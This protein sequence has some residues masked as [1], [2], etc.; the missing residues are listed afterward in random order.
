MEKI[1]EMVKITSDLIRIRSTHDRQDQIAKCV[2][3]VADFF[4]ETELKVE[5][6]ESDGVA[7]LVVTKNTNS[8]TVFLCGHVDVVDGQEKQFL[9][10]I[11]EDKIFGRGAMDMKSG[12]AIM[13]I[14]M[15]ELSTTE[16]NFGLMIV[17]DE[18]IGGANGS[19][20][21][22][23]KGYRCK[24]VVIADGGEKIN[25]II[26]KEK[27][28]LR[29]K[30]TA[31]GKSTHSSRPW[32]GINANEILIEAIQKIKTLFI[33][34][35]E[36]PE[37]HWVKT[38]SVGKI[39]GGIAYNQVPASAQAECNIRYTENETR[40]QIISSIKAVLP[41]NVEIEYIGICDGF[42]LEKEDSMVQEYQKAIESVGKTPEFLKT[43]GGSDAGYFAK[44]GI[45]VLMSQPEGANLHA[46]GE[47]V[48]I[49]SMVDYYKMLRSFLNSVALK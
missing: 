28:S 25:R 22:L 23:E 39:N 18:E 31:S 15:K 49:S 2:D 30:L 38:L 47:Y 42:K 4:K 5:R 27:A 7:S 48:Y 19:A 11:E 46:D 32:L 26:E 45:P 9:P 8:P 3:Y 6:F 20:F 29:I 40:D 14:L 1:D 36:H 34:L 10:E 24:S 13:M 44:L 43:H 35:D 16:H 21:L 33:N 41:E 12:V 17:G 37:D